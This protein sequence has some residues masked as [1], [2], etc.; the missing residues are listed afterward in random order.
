MT[1]TAQRIT[2]NSS[3]AFA[4]VNFHLDFG[5][6]IRRGMKADTGFPPLALEGEQPNP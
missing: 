6:A 4:F 5:A 1:E 3:P 2:L